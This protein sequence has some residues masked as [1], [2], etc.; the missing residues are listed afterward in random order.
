MDGL[1]CIR[2]RKHQIFV[3]A[4]QGCAAKILSAEVHLL[5]RGAGGAVK[6]QHRPLGTMQPL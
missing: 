5:Q 1:H 2:P 6:H 4:F 3:A